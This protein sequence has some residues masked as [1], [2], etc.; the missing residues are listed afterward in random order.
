[1]D[2]PSDRVREDEIRLVLPD[3]AGREPFLKLAAAVLA[4]RCH[5]VRVE[6]NLAATALSLG[7]REARHVIRDGKCLTNGQAGTIEVDSVP[8]KASSGLVRYLSP[9]RERHRTSS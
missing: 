1:M 5:R 6:R 3:V 8:G 9:G 2:W 7:C 4:K